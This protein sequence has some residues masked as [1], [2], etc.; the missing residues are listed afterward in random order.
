MKIYSDTFG[1][2]ATRKTIKEA[3]CFLLKN[4][5]ITEETEIYNEDEDDFIPL[6]ELAKDL[7]LLDTLLS[8]YENNEDF[9]DGEFSFIKN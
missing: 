7:P 4:S 3:F 8:L 9:L 1:Y 2:L 5:L 6:G